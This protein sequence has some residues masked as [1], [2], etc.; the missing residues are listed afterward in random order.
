MNKIMT[1]T[2]PATVSPIQG[3]FTEE[4]VS[5]IRRTICP[6]ATEDELALFVQRCRSTGLDP[7]TGQIY[8]VKRK[9]SPATMQTG[10]D[11]FRL[12]AQRT[13]ERDGMDAPQWCGK[14]GVF[15]PIWTGSEP[16]VACTITVYRKGHSKGYPAIA[17]WDFYAQTKAGGELNYMWSK[18]GPHML[19]KCS[20]ALALR[21]A[22]PNELSGLYTADEMHQ[23]S[24][25]TPLLDAPQITA[26][27]AQRAT[28]IMEA[29]RQTNSKQEMS[30]LTPQ[31]KSLP[32]AG[33]IMVR[34]AWA[35]NVARLER[36]E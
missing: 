2:Q 22:F 12:V 8:L 29:L 35:E 20:E 17:Y 19:A 10:I 15:M 11:G 5:L 24:E 16:P 32:E 34:P 18:G 6:E 27:I 4:Q 21:Q 25:V 23:A 7:F 31:I 14:D 1:S 3:S 30:D 26:E 33:K 36:E 13:G 9:G 28:K